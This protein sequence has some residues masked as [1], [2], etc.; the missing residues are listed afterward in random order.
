MAFDTPKR[1]TSAAGAACSVTYSNTSAKKLRAKGGGII[2]SYSAD[3]TGGGI[4]VVAGSLT[5]LDVDITDGGLGFLPFA[6]FDIPKDNVDDVVVTLKA[7]GGTVVGKL[8]TTFK[9]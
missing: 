4:T 9:I 3:P 7:P 8:N 6:G 5:L 2:F 1:A